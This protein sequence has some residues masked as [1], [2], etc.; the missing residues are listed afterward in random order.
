MGIRAKLV[1]CLLAVLIPLC[2]ISTFAFHLFDQQ[3]KERTESALSNTQRIETLRISEILAG[4]SQDALSLA[5]DPHVQE[6]VTTID[7]YIAAIKSNPTKALQ[8]PPTIGGQ[9]GLALIDFS[10]TWPL[11]QLALDLHHKAGIVGSAVA[12][13]RIVSRDG[14]T[15]GETMGF[16]WQPTDGALVERAMTSVKTILGEAFLT[17]VEQQRIGVVSPIVSDM[18]EVVGALVLE[19]PLNPI[20]DILSMHE[21]IGLTTEALIVQKT[22][23]GD[24]QLLTAL[25]FDRKSAFT[26]II[27][28]SK[29]LPTN[30]AL[31][32]QFS[33]VI[34]APDYRGVYSISSI[35]TIPATG[36][37]L[38]VKIDKREAYAPLNALRSLL[39]I[40]TAISLLL[41]L[42]GYTICL[43][44]VAHRLKKTAHAARKIMNG[45]LTVRVCD[46]ANDEIGNMAR[47]IDSLALQ[48]EQ[49][50]RKRVR[51]ENQLRHQATHDELTGLLN[52][53]Y[54]N[55]LIEELNNE[56]AKTHTVMFLDLN[57][58]K[59][60]NDFYG[61]AAGDEVLMTVAERL[62][63]ATPSNGTLARWGGD[64]FVIVLP[65]TDKNSAEIFASTVHAEFE[66]PISTSEGNHEISTSIGLATSHSGKSLQQA[67]IEADSLM[68][69]EKKKLKSSR[70]ITSMA[71]RTLERAL[72][73]NRIE[74]W[75][76]PIVNFDS[77]GCEKLY[78]ADVKIRIRTSEGGIILPEE[79]LNDIGNTPLNAALYRHALFACATSVKRWTD[80]KIVSP[81]FKLHF[82]LNADILA[83]KQFTDS[84]MQFLRTEGQS[85]ASHI[86]FN[87]NS[88]WQIDNSAIVQFRSEGLSIATIHS[89]ILISTMQSEQDYQ[90][91]LAKADIKFFNDDILAPRLIADFNRHGVRV[92]VS[93]VNSREELS[94]LTLL[95]VVLF[96]GKLF[97]GPMRASDFLSRWGQPTANS[98]TPLTK[99]NFRL[100]L[101]G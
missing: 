6:F 44:P 3:L 10:A 9:D 46:Y 1:F 77:S 90:P 62:V 57:G 39:G 19:T 100:R 52:R 61:H 58:F 30:Q 18:G 45:D 74:L 95:G 37:G 25:R 21:R 5:T 101:A 48:L 67:L 80:S 82:E 64:E 85:I 12:E 53:K 24:A 50:H 17:D 33:R 69:E 51:I 97:D 71:T 7:S 68:Y 54:A 47:T 43:G 40:A 28:S 56:P 35:Q 75:Y 49:D 22:A 91:D 14:T 42:A 31:D 34:E 79:L 87:I 88:I 93:G 8:N 63:R 65:D 83:S 11:Q 81:D 4:Y 99:S 41:I 94:K 76:E 72:L 84:A 20:T 29:N 96:Q 2:A 66:T 23:S 32:A 16:T 38:V 70:S 26:K 89:G 98:L 59:D 13:L 78:A 92:C 73:E 36:W 15:L 55:K 60:V 27:S 86:T